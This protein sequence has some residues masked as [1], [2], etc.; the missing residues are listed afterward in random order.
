MITYRLKI[1]TQCKRFTSG[2]QLPLPHCPSPLTHLPHCPFP[3]DTP[4]PLPLPHCPSPTAPP[5]LTHLLLQFLSRTID[6]VDSEEWLIELGNAMGDKESIV[7]SYSSYSQEK[8]FLFKCLG[9]ILKKSNQKQFVPK[10]LDTIFAT[11]RH[12][13]QEEREVS[14]CVHILLACVHWCDSSVD[15]YF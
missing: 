6:E 14:V 13:S 8:S 2:N 1:S 3:T 4:P 9:I 10:H 7:S 15:L 5:P 11:V 12:A